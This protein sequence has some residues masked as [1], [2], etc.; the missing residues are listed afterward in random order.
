MR[1]S[2]PGPAAISACLIV[3]SAM[4]SACSGSCPS[5]KDARTALQPIMPANF[6]VKE[7]RALRELPS[8]CESVVVTDK[9]PIVVYL[10]KKGKV[11]FS[12]SVIEL[13]SKKNLTMERLKEYNK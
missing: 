10:D 7:V 5:P 9:Q 8:L 11:I 12:G 1:V 2:L 4:I 3:I 6:E 13:A